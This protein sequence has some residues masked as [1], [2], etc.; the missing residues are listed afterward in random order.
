V[1]WW[2]YRAFTDELH[3]GEHEQRTTSM[4]ALQDWLSIRPMDPRGLKAF[5]CDAIRGLSA[6][7]QPAVEEPQLL[8]PGV[9]RC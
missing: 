3:A 4:T 1:A 2:E 5:I 7:Q 9:E 8:R 6:A